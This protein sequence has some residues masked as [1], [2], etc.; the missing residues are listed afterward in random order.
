LT[1]L[2]QIINDLERQKT[3]INNALAALRGLSADTPQRRGPGR[4]LGT[5]G[6][7]RPP[8]K[9]STIS[10]E[11]RQRIAEA[12]RE[13]WAAKKA[14]AK[15]AASK[16]VGNTGSK[17]AASAKKTAARKRSVSKKAAA[18]KSPPASQTAS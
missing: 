15:K 6:P 18:K 10:E 13:R 14:A 11:G 5:R 2:Q 16:T 17:A 3:A 8:K 4:P 7:G 12:Q 1:D 9:R